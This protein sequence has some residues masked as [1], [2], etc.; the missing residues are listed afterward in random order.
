MRHDDNHTYLTR[1]LTKDNKVAGLSAGLSADSHSASVDLLLHNKAVA[2]KARKRFIK[3]LKV[4]TT[5]IIYVP[6]K[7]R[8]KYH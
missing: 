7:Q 5:T 6:G 2:K 3:K 4:V 8:I 1:N